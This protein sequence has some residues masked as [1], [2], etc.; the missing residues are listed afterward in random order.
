M[1]FF[2]HSSDLRFEFLIA[3]TTFCVNDPLFLLTQSS[4]ITEKNENKTFYL[5]K[6]YRRFAGLFKFRVERIGRVID[7]VIH[8]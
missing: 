6:V 4:R 7:S 8:S 2:S 5:N 1:H 3:K